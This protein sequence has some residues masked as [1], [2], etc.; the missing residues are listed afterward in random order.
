MMLQSF[1][2]DFQVLKY[3]GGGGQLEEESSGDKQFDV[4]L[5]D[6]SVPCLRHAVNR[7]IAVPD[8]TSLHFMRRAV[9]A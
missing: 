8:K 2:A 1:V 4:A 7:T 3:D 6:A 9:Q 5:P